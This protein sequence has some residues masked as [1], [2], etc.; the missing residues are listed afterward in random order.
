LLDPKLDVV[1][2]MLF[3][4]E[5]SRGLLISLLDAVLRPTARIV[6]VTVLNPELPAGG[7]GDKGIVVDLLVRLD[8]GSLVDVEMQTHSRPG[9]QARALYYWARMVGSELH[10]GEE[11]AD[12]RRAAVV[13]LLGYRA[14]PDAPFHG[15]WQVRERRSSVLL[16]D[17]LEIHTVELPKLD[18]LPAPERDAE[19]AL[20]RWARFFCARDERELAKL[21]TMDSVMSQA[22]SILEEL[23][24]EPSAQEAARQRE[25]GLL[26]WNHSHYVA[27][28]EGRAE[29]RVEGRAEA[30]KG[31]L[32][33]ALEARSIVLDEAD[34][35]RIHTCTDQQQLER[36]LR[37]AITATSI[38]DVL[39]G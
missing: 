9:G 16:S 33:V 18:E 37:A 38:A 12:M 21:A 5:R 20:V 13:L 32:L 30:T 26:N 15:V 1:F 6:E 27:R 4:A 8:D 22:K 3:A 24:G 35:A 23:S 10:R 28:Q 36:W 2:K 29:G 19:T 7:W 14:F 17:L 11:Y 31:A 34:L 39:S 25:L